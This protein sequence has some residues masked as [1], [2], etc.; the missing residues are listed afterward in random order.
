VAYDV[1]RATLF[2]DVQVR[3]AQWRYTPDVHADVAPASISWTFV[4]PRGGL[5]Y[6]LAPSLSLYAS[7][8]TMSREPAR[9]DMLA[10]FDNLDTSNVAFVGPLSRVKPETVHDIESGVNVRTGALRF[11]GNI[12][13]MDFRNEIEPI[14]ALSYLGLPLR[15]NVRASYRRGVELDA[16]YMLPA[17]FSASANATIMNAKI[18]DYTDDSS[19]ETFHDVEPLL[20]PKVTTAQRLTWQGTRRFTISLGGRYT[21]RSQLDNTGNPN[22]VL[23][24]SYVMDGLFEWHFAH[25][26]HALALRGENLTNS[27]RYGSGYSGDRP[28]YYVL[29]PRSLF[30]TLELGF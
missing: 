17:G 10:G 3:R 18:A 8:G 26:R 21:G 25:G 9:N 30:A 23:P 5:T 15:K 24:S 27:K 12:F 6:R 14:G 22:M 4:N 29:Q 2:G 11:E 28:Y 19:G 7:Y 13:S 20:T 16:G 1:G